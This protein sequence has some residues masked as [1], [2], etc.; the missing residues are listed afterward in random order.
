MTPARLL[1]ASQNPGKRREMTLLLGGLPFAVVAPA[2][3][4][5]LEAPEE[6]GRTFLENAVLKAG[7]YSRRT[8][9]HLAVADDSGLGVDALDGAPGLHSARFGGPGA[10]DHARNRL[11]LERLDGIPPE[12][13]GAR[14]VCAVA[15]VRGDAVLFTA[16]EEVEGRIA[17]E[18]R[19]DQGFGYDPLFFFP[20]FGRTFG[21]VASAMK[22]RVSHRGKAFARLRGFLAG[23]D[24]GPLRT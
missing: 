1:V 12:R 19:G 14:F 11:L 16:Q 15:L 8:G 6:T 23:G 13:R 17:L 21:E 3:L 22:D 18:P 2:D 4:G 24:G 20:P 7:W 9:D 10:D 5:V